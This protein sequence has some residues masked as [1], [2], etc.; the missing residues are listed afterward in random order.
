MTIY[1]CTCGLP[2]DSMTELMMH[3]L[4]TDH[5]GHTVETVEKKEEGK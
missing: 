2:F 4:S 5:E 3:Q 1:R